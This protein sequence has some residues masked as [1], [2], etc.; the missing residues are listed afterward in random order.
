[1]LRRVVASILFLGGLASLVGPA[2]LAFSWFIGADVQI[3]GGL[4]AV[5]TGALLTLLLFW[6]SASV[7]SAGRAPAR[8]PHQSPG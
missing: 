4:F 1:M 3:R 2:F 5:L 7:W 8:R 6:G